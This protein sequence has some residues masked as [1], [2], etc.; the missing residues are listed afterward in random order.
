MNN[1]LENQVYDEKLIR[2]QFKIFFIIAFGLNYLM[3]LGI[4]YGES[5]GIDINIFPVFQMLTPALG[6]MV[7]FMLT[8]EK[9]VPKVSFSIY[10]AVST[11]VGILAIASLFI[12]KFP[13]VAVMNGTLMVGTILF[14]IGMLIDKKQK[15]ILFNLNTVSAKKIALMVVL[16]LVLYFLRV[17]IGVVAT[18][19]IAEFKSYF[20]VQKILYAIILIPNFFFVFLPFLGEEYG[21]RYFLQPIM[22]KKYGMVKGILLLGLIW[23]VW[24]LPLNLFYYS[25]NNTGILSLVNQIGVC[26][27]YSIMF[28]F[29]YSYSKSI[30]AP[31]MMHY[32]NNNLTLFFTDNLDPSVLENNIYTWE[33]VAANFVMGLIIY[34]VFIFSKY[35]RREEFRIQTP[36]ERLEGGFLD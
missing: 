7:A 14:I 10:I 26:L 35:N 25:A 9:R 20:T 11:V 3:G 24:H 16:F 29:A 13:G 36:H 33:V 27:A 19:G 30:W 1:E 8:K 32:F 18:E 23:G 34:G 17:A 5:K 15:R 22:Q 21:W 4:Y 12:E 2:R 6:V 28:G 31:V